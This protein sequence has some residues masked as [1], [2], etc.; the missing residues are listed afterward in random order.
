MAIAGCEG[1]C[2]VKTGGRAAVFHLPETNSKLVSSDKQRV[3]A[4]ETQLDRLKAVFPQA[5]TQDFAHGAAHPHPL[6]IRL[7]TGVRMGPD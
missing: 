1:V 4:A 5:E 3:V 2:R 6:V 7:S